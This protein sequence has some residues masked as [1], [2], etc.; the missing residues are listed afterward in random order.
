M[1]ERRVDSAGVSDIAILEI[2]RDLEVHFRGERS[3]EVVRIEVV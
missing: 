3:Q 2:Y 1:G